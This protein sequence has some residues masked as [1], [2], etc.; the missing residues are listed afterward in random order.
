M[1]FSLVPTGF[2]TMKRRKLADFLFVRGR[3]VCPWW[4]CFTFDNVFRRLFQNPEKILKPHVHPGETALD[5]GPGMGYFTIPLARLVGE[6]G[7]VIAADI[8]ERMLSALGKRARR[9]GLEQR[10]TL[11]L[12]SPESLGITTKIDFILTFW[13]VHE[14]PDKQRF[15]AELVA[16]MKENGRYLLVEPK[17]HVRN[18][19]FDETIHLAEQAGFSQLG[20]PAIAFSRSVLF[21]KTRG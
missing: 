16:L 7:R 18:T 1:I 21:M 4:F 9:S 13:M 20:S 5:V 15:F 14:V 2:Y 3:H 19:A 11:Q 6:N 8:Q 17:L 10:I 12:S